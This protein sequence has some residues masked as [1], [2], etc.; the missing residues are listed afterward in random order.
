MEAV[1]APIS[2]MMICVPVIVKR[3]AIKGNSD[4]NKGKELKDPE[5]QRRLFC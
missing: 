4:L 5:Y 2:T 1:G 3:V